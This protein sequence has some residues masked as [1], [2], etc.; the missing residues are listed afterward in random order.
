[1]LNL[2]SSKHKAV[3]TRWATK[4]FP[5]SL[6]AANELLNRISLNWSNFQY[7]PCSTNC[8][9]FSEHNMRLTIWL[10][11]QWWTNLVNWDLFRLLAVTIWSLL[12]WSLFIWT[13][14]SKSVNKHLNVS[15]GLTNDICLNRSCKATN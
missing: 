9:W 1:M 15:P 14:N 6:L 10:T 12:I 13:Q 4:H 5:G 3:Q 11:D 8:Y 2:T 7:K